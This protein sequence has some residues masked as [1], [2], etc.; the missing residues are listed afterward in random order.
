MLLVVPGRNA[1]VA[2]VAP[3]LVNLHVLREWRWGASATVEEALKGYLFAHL[4]LAPGGVVYTFGYILC[5]WVVLYWLY[6]RR[7][8]F[9]V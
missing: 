1:I 3:I 9:R 4:G 8:F 7:I 5:W 6:R 2:F